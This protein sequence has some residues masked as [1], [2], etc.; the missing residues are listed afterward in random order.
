MEDEVKRM[1]D[2]N[3]KYDKIYNEKYAGRNLH[4]PAP[5]TRERLAILET[6][7]KL[8]MEENR[9]EHEEM[10]TSMTDF[11]SAMLDSMKEMNT[12]LDSALEKK[13]DKIVVDRILSLLFWFGGIVGAGI[14]GYLGTLIVRVIEKL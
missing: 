12:K 5:E 13:A 3:D 11:H 4:E 1:K 9:K 8:F 7:Q 2:I 10:K 14:L 6:S